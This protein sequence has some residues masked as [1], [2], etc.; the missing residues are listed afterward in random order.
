MASG[1]QEKKPIP[2]EKFQVLIARELHID[3]DLIRRDSSFIHDL[4]ADSL[5]LVE[6]MLHMEELGIKIPLE[7]AW[8]IDTV[9]DAYQIYLDHQPPEEQS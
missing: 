3:K 4:Q 1:N 9:G 6:M 5:Q 2:F 7:S 8:E